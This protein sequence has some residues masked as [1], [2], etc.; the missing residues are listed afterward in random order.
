MI[1]TA[2]LAATGTRGVVRFR[3]RKQELAAAHFFAQQPPPPP[4][5]PDRWPASE[6]VNLPEDAGD[7]GMG[8]IQLLMPGD[9]GY[10]A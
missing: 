8:G 10:D 7:G 6:F 4:P 1:G 5:P 3:Q 2:W 9:P